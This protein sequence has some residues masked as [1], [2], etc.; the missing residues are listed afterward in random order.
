MAAED[1]CGPHGL[2][3]FH[4]LAWSHTLDCPSSCFVSQQTLV[5]PRMTSVYK[6]LHFHWDFCQP[7]CILGTALHH[8]PFCHRSLFLICSLYLLSLRPVCEHHSYKPSTFQ[9]NLCVTSFGLSPWGQTS[10]QWG[11]WD[12]SQTTGSRVHI[13][14]LHYVCNCKLGSLLPGTFP[15][16]FSRFQEVSEHCQHC[17]IKSFHLTIS[18]EVVWCGPGPFYSTVFL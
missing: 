18:L 7:L 2:V 8:G 9:H 5:P 15:V 10:S 13:Q 16:C 14:W 6:V 4:F 12:F 3:L 1:S 17:S 11:V